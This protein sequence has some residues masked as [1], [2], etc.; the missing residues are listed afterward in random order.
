MTGY[1]N[2]LGF[3]TGSGL[4]IFFI[5]ANDLGVNITT[6]T[7]VEFTLDNVQVATFTHYPTTSTNFDYNQT[8]Y[9]NNSIPYGEH[10]MTIAPIN[11]SVDSILILFDYLIY[12]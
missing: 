6:M 7:N 12:T 11:D 2:D 1:P 9:A 4:Y 10:T 5:L 3:H 8:V